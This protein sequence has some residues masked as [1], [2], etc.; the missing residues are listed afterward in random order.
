[1][2]WT[3]EAWYRIRSLAGQDAIDNGLNEEIRFHIEQQNRPARQ[4]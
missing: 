3:K 4:A 2:G 1:M